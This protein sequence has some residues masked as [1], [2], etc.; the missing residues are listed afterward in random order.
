VNV[1]SSFHIVCHHDL[2]TAQ[3][4][5][6]NKKLNTLGLDY[7][8]WSLSAGTGDGSAQSSSYV[9]EVMVEA[10]KLCNNQPLCS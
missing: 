7:F 6:R 8:R 3:H 2:C 5:T 10:M 4:S 9:V 1:D